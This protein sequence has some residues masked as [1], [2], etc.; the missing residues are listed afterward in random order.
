MTR[1]TTLFKQI[2]LL[3]TYLGGEGIFFSGVSLR[4]LLSL[5]SLLLS[6]IAGLVGAN[7][8]SVDSA[9]S[10]MDALLPCR[11]C[12]YEA[13]VELDDGREMSWPMDGSCLSSFVAGGVLMAGRSKT[14]K[15]DGL[16]KQSVA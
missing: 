14:C 9:G 16:R 10:W 8:A 15:M 7:E 2:Q 5:L 12:V 4:V 11:C 1:H 3:Q 13:T 6:L